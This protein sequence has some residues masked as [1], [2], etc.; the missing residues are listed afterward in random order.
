M[1]LKSNSGHCNPAVT[2]FK[3]ITKEIDGKEG[4]IRC[5]IQIVAALIGGLCVMLLDPKN[6][7]DGEV[8]NNVWYTAK[9]TELAST[10]YSALFR[11]LSF[12]LN[13]LVL[14]LTYAYL[15]KTKPGVIKSA[16][17]FIIVF[18]SLSGTSSFTSDSGYNL[19]HELGTGFF[20]NYTEKFTSSDSFYMFFIG[21]LAGII[22]GGCLGHFVFWKDG[23]EA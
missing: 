21:P 10:D 9:L 12:L 23:A 14:G 15:A 19:L 17:A 8:G 1:G 22:G 20:L 7:N 5:A 16:F 18:Y 11:W 4:G 13:P 2:L 6:A 3:M